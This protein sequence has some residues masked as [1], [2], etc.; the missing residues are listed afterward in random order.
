MYP[1]GGELEYMGIDL[2]D[3]RKI[4]QAPSLP[5]PL[6]ASNESTREN[7]RSKTLNLHFGLG[8]CLRWILCVSVGLMLVGLGVI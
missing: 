7:G 1:E 8:W 6:F 3:L 4:V 5:R 2:T